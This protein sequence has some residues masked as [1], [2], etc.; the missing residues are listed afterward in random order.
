MGIGLGAEKMAAPS[1]VWEARTLLGEKCRGGVG[2][3]LTGEGVK[4]RSLAE[5][6]DDVGSLA[7]VKKGVVGIVI[8]DNGGGD[9]M[10][11]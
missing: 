10:V 1:V 6:G 5:E 8:V 4:R 11:R 2:G 9:S 3:T 7:R